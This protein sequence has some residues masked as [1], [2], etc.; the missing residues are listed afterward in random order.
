MFSFSVKENMRF[1][2]E[3]CFLYFIKVPY[4][5]SDELKHYRLALKIL[6]M[7]KYVIDRHRIINYGFSDLFLFRFCKTRAK[8]QGSIV[9]IHIFLNVRYY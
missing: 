4:M 9:N 8:F 3:K 2:T 1:Y 5:K 6:I 7:E